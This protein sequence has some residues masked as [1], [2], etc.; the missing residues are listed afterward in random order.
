M[1]GMRKETFQ[2]LAIG[3]GL[4]ALFV[5]AGTPL[6]IWVASVDTCERMT[7]ELMVM[8]RPLSDPALCEAWF[9][10]FR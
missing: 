5:A 6:C 4:L 10:L 9:A 1:L 2:A 8:N 3:M 7:C